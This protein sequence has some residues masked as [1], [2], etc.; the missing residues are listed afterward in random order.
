MASLD[1]PLTPAR[2]PTN[3]KAND[4]TDEYLEGG[5]ANQ[6]AQALLGEVLALKVFVNHVVED[7]CLDADGA[8]YADCVVHDDGSDDGGDGKGG[9][10]NTIEPGDGCGQGDNPGVLCIEWFSA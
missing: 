2:Q 7:T 10:V 1:E 4:C 8:P 6:F 3:H 9:R 5:M